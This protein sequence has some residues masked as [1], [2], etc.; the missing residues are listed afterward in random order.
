M[1]SKVPVYSGLDGSWFWSL[2][3][4][5]SKGILGMV[6]RKAATIPVPTFTAASAGPPLSSLGSSGIVC[7]NA[8]INP[9]YPPLNVQFL[10]HDAPM[11]LKRDIT[12]SLRTISR[13]QCAL[14]VYL[15][16]CSLV[17]IRTLTTSNGVTT[18]L[19]TVPVSAPATGAVSIVSFPSFPATMRFATS[20]PLYMQSVCGRRQAANSPRYMPPMPPTAYCVRRA[21][22]MVPFGLVLT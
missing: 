9:K 5:M 1:A 17:C 19:S 10:A 15:A 22:R 6:A 4:A 2:L 12:P 16:M 8:N 21:P 11:P 3:F 13:A 18:K 7:L 14:L 20:F